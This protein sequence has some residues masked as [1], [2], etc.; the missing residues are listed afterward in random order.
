MK[1]RLKIFLERY[2]F[3]FSSWTICLWS[4]C[5]VT[6]WTWTVWVPMDWKL[7]GRLDS[8]LWPISLSMP[9]ATMLLQVYFSSYFMDTFILWLCKRL[10]LI[11]C[12]N[13]WTTFPF[14]YLSRNI[15]CSSVCFKIRLKWITIGLISNILTV[16]LL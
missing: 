11:L 1:R 2:D 5:W 8:L 12:E 7:S 13:I 4:Q 9:S 16:L 15:A 6:C 14:E 10:V 3:C